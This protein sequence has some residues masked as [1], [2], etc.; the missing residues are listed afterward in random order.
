[1]VA[2]A[3]VP[4][5]ARPRQRVHVKAPG[6]SALPGFAFPNRSPSFYRID[7]EPSG[8]KGLGAVGGG[9]RH[10]DRDISRLEQAGP[11]QQGHAAQR[12]PSPPHF[13]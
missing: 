6:T 9:H 10:H 8:V 12:G 3:L 7:P 2:P 4:H 11:V 5:A 1:M 13:L